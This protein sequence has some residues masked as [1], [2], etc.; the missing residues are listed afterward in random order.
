MTMTIA[1]LGRPDAVAEVA[2]RIDEF[3][4]RMESMALPHGRRYAELWSAARLSSEGGK[5]FR[6]ALV[7]SAHQALG[8]DHHDDVVAVATAFELLHTAFL[9]HDD[10]I[11][12]DTMRRG[13]PN[14]VGAF[15]A[16]ASAGGASPAS[17]SSWGTAS[18]ILAGD[19]LIHAAQA[20]IARLSIA[21]DRR[22]A[23][24]DLLEETMFVTAAGE[25]ADVAFGTGVEVP[26]LDETL[27][28][29][30]WKTAHYS[31]QAPLLAGAILAGAPSETL[32]ALGEFGHRIGVAFQLRDDVL[33]VFGSERVTG[34]SASSDLRSGKVT[35]MMCYALQHD[36]DRELRNALALGVVTEQDECR[37]RELLERSGAR[38][39]AETMIADCTRTA[40]M[41]LDSPAVPV[42][43]REQLERVAH[44]A[45]ERVS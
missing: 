7:I 2:V 37:V 36:D 16:Q 22:S 6:P 42:S 12:G 11:D 34:K 10:V 25:L 30:Q 43:L 20:Q 14:L 35:P 3:F 24:L 27:S 21:N 31:F 28:M 13:R 32:Q 5:R 18:A 44:E 23:L 4:A 45:R 38:E 19:L 1:Q 17:A 26:A 41:A 29:T 39:F 8:G 15:A 40:S 9:L 33:G